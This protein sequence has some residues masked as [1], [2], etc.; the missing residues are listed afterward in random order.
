MATTD[1]TA[2][3]TLPDDPRELERLAQEHLTVARTLRAAGDRDAAERR[4]TDAIRGGLWRYAR[5]WTELRS[6]MEEPADYR[7]IRRLWW[8]SP[9]SCH[10][11]VPLHT[12]IARAAAAAGEHDEARTIL[13]KATVLQGMRAKRIRA[14]LGRLKHGAIR[15][16]KQVTPGDD[17]DS[18]EPRAA[19][20]LPELDAEFAALGVRGFLI[21]G[22]LL[23]YVREGGFIS[24][25][26]DIDLGFFTS[27]MSA[28]DLERSFER[29]KTFHVR[30]LD[31]NTDRLRVNHRNGMM[32]D[33]FPHY[34][35]TDG[36]VWHDGTATRWW[37]TPFELT[38]V[39]FLGRPQFVPDPPE[40]YLDENYGDWRVPEPGFDARLDAPNA[41][42][43]DRDF[44]DTLS[45]FALLD[46]VVK[47]DPAKI[48]RYGALLRDLGEG[49]WLDRL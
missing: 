13:R 41:E 10:G 15:Q 24:W 46:G 47:Q 28:A 33:L 2:P 16:V 29:S 21:S 7:R 20:A 25:D 35:D 17:A 48:A 8:D 6:M 44:L 34:H 19:E 4:L 11:V 3:A 14:R 18:F 42:V 5:L 43:T 40:R 9:R 32:I 38:T 1:G 12:T 27:E 31:F 45:Y 26:K 49:D 39:D 22:T 36:R 30:R 37:N 23:G